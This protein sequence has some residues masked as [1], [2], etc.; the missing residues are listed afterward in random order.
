MEFE[1]PHQAMIAV[2]KENNY[3]IDKLH[4]FKTNLFTD[5]KKFEEIS[6][7]WEPPISQPFKGAG[8]LHSFLLDQDAYDQFSVLSGNSSAVSVQIWQN[9]APEPSLLEERMV[10][11]VI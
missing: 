2:A 10:N 1:N 3:K 11:I 5:F 4:T 8:D 6:K 7:D 9:S